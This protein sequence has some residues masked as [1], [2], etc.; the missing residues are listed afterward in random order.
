ME[1]EGDRVQFSTTNEFNASAA[2]VVEALR[3]PEFYGSLDSLPDIA[4]PE[5]VSHTVTNDSTLLIVRYRFTGQ[6]D[7]FVRRLIGN[8][9]LSWLQ[10]TRFED[11]AEQAL[12]KIESEVA[13]DLLR[14]NG[15]MVFTG[16]RRS[17]TRVMAANLDVRIP[18]IAG[19]VANSLVPGIVARIDAEAKGLNDWL[20]G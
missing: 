10:H 11:G 12:V 2:H 5:V 8:E 9:P 16:T 19:R 4:T 6:I 14:C 20:A 13:R 1:P 7:G 15:T 17:S 3:D 18:F